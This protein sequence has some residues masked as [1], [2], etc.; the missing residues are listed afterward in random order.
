MRIARQ[1]WWTAGFLALERRPHRRLRPD[2]DRPHRVALAAQMVD[3]DAVRRRR[4]GRPQKLRRAVRLR[5]GRARLPPGAAQHLFVYAGLSI[6][7]LIPLSIL[8]GVIV[9]RAAVRGTTLLRTVLF[10]TYCVPMIAV[11]EIVWSKLYSPTEGP[12]NQALGWF[13]I[14]PQPWLSDTGTALVSLV[15]L[16]VWQLARLL[17]RA[18]R[19]GPD[20]DPAVGLRGGRARRRPQRQAAVQDHAAAAARAGCCCS[21]VIRADQRD[22][23]LWRAGRDDHPG[24]PGRIDQRPHLP[25]PPGRGSSARRA[26]SPRGWRLRCC[27]RSDG[28]RDAGIFALMRKGQTDENPRSR[29]APARRCSASC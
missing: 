9:H 28:R 7:L 25:H 4:M 15:F 21:V 6:A 1:N 29:S 8:F 2:P 23:G 3:G 27:S 13:G 17:H 19:R 26:A 22:P 11:V 20:A 12:V 16:N 5:A 24:R 10:A 18:G 14:G